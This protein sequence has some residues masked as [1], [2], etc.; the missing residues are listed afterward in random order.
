MSNREIIRTDNVL[1]RVMELG[2]DGATE[3]HHHTEMR[4]FFVC[5]TGAILVETRNPDG[6]IMLLPGQHAE[7]SPMTAHRVSNVADAG[8]EYLLVQGVGSYDFIRDESPGG[9]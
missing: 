2:K 8:T 5:L 4:D 3:W 7:A 1:V 9:S 6:Q